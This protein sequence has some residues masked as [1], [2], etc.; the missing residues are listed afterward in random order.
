MVIDKKIGNV[1]LFLSKFKT[2][3]VDCAEQYLNE[4]ITMC[5]RGDLYR[6]TCDFFV[7]PGDIFVYR[8]VLG[9][10]KAFAK[11]HC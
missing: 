6:H 4:L 7:E 10:K 8:Y 2:R 11:L 1:E 3:K 9:F 5:S